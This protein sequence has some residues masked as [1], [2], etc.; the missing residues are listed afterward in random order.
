MGCFLKCVIRQALHSFPVLL[1]TELS[2]VEW[3]LGVFSEHTYLFIEEA[4]DEFTL[5]CNS[6]SVCWVQCI[7]HRDFM[8]LFLC[9][10]SV[11]CMV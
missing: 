6:L 10:F 4:V 5:R 8:K 11:F 9:G 3:F 2:V 1:S 7:P